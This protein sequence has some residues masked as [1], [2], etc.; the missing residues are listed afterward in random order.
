VFTGFNNN[1]GELCPAFWVDF[2]N[3]GVMDNPQG[4]R[5]YT[6]SIIQYNVAYTDW[7]YWRYC[8][9]DTVAGLTDC[10]N[11]PRASNDSGIGG[12]YAA[13]WGCEN[14]GSANGMGVANGS[15]DVTI[16]SAGYQKASNPGTW[17]YTEDSDL[18]TEDMPSYY[19]ANQVQNTYGESVNCRTL[20]HQ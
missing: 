8:V 1:T 20:S 12:R 16:K 5:A 7:D 15:G 9:T 3:D 2:N 11:Q 10:Y 17:Y 6:M 18:N 13:W 4:G 19:T 14:T